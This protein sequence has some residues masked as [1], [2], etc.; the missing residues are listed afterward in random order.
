[1]S[2]TT[3]NQI[4][5]SVAINSQQWRKVQARLIPDLGPTPVALHR[6]LNRPGWSLTVIECGLVICRGPTQKD[7]L[8]NY[9]TLLTQHSAQEILARVSN[10]GKA[11]VSDGLPGYEKKAPTSNPKWKAEN[12]ADAIAARAGLDQVERNAV[13]RALSKIGPNAG[14]LLKS[15]P[16]GYDDPLAQAAWNGIQPNPYKVQATCLLFARGDDKI[17]LNKLLAKSWPVWLDS[18]ASALVD[19]GVW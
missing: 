10:A 11:P 2:T 1:M 14:R 4:E 8:K 12:V 19:L 15:A 5:I 13:W 16:R 17:L 3:K 18:D 9:Q 7:C 6:S